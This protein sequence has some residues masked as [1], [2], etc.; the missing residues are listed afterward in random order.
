MPFRQLHYRSATTLIVSAILI[1]L[2]IGFVIA[3]PA[4]NLV[5]TDITSP[6]QA[7][8]TPTNTLFWWRY[9]QIAM[10]KEDLATLDL[11]AETRQRYEEEVHRMEASLTAIAE[12]RTALAATPRISSDERSV[13]SP[14]STPVATQEPAPTGILEDFN[15]PPI[16]KGVRIIS[17]WQNRVGEGWVEVYSGNLSDDLEQGVIFAVRRGETTGVSNQTGG[18]ILAPG[19]GGALRITDSHGHI[20][21][22]RDA[23][24]T[25]LRFD[26]QTM[27]FVVQ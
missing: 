21:T 9:E 3:Q 25:L 5:A 16:L 4:E 7:T 22:L 15:T 26:T 27:N 14:A 20:L 19:K 2:V 12:S 10:L 1:L 11:D 24:G 18:L 8:E 6:P 23:E 17:A 13:T